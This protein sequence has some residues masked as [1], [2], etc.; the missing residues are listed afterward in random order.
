MNNPP[1]LNPQFENI[2]SK[3]KTWLWLIWVI[4]SFVFLF[5]LFTTQ[6]CSP[7]DHLNE[8]GSGLCN[9]A[10]PVGIAVWLYVSILWINL[11]YVFLLKRNQSNADYYKKLIG[12]LA[13]LCFLILIGFAASD[14]GIRVSG[15]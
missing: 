9:A 15:L 3:K 11:S 8:L 4:G 2:F 7:Y 1:T 5:H 6:Y 10:Y 13:I 14:S 12:L